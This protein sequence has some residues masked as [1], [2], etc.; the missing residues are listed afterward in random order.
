MLNLMW[1][2]LG[3]IAVCIGFYFLTE[4][5][6]GPIVWLFLAVVIGIAFNRIVIDGVSEMAA[7]MRSLVLKKLGGTH[8]KFQNFTVNVIEDELH[9]RWIATD[10]VR[11]IIGQLA[12]D[13]ALGQIFRAGHQMEGKKGYL[14][15]DALV[16]HLA[17]ATTPQAIK[18]KNWVERNIGFPARKTRERLGIKESDPCVDPDDIE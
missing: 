8:Y 18:F 4:R 11:K 2:T 15:D 10:Q 5:W 9:Y 17:N 13:H 16:A 12:G 6:L 14:R 1:R 3:A 7:G